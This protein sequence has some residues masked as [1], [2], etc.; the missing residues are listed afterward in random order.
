MQTD[1]NKKRLD[2]DLK[3]M[4]SES[5]KP[6]LKQAVDKKSKKEMIPDLQSE[7]Q[8]FRQQQLDAD[9]KLNKAAEANTLKKLNNSN[10]ILKWKKFTTFSKNIEELWG[11]IC[12]ANASLQ[13]IASIPEA[14]SAINSF[15]ENANIYYMLLHK[16]M[17]A[18]ASHTVVQFAKPP[19]GDQ[20]EAHTARVPAPPSTGGSYCT[21]KSSN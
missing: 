15:K 8:L 14:V 4:V 20:T 1:G 11:N 5:Q 10:N 13:V 2:F 18:I 6:V 9:I 7:L 3:K 12:F 16:L 19:A 17:P 21:S